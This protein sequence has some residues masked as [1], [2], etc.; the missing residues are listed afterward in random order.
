MRYLIAA[1]VLCA[2]AVVAA[3][4]WK[5]KQPAEW[6]EPEATKIL[7]ESPWVKS[8][9]PF[10]DPKVAR[11]SRSAGMGSRGGSGNMS[12]VGP[13]GTN[14]GGAGGTPLRLPPVRVSFETSAAVSDAKLRLKLQDLY[15]EQRAEN[16]VVSVLG[17]P[18]AGDVGRGQKMPDA[19]RRKEMQ[20]D[21]QER[22]TQMT[23]L[24][25][26]NDRVFQPA[27]VRLQKTV[28]GQVVLFVFRR[29][30]LNLH[31]DDKQIVFKT[32]MGPLEVD[33][34]FNLKE[35]VYQGKLSL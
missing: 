26:S 13:M 33:V 21:L 18:M 30:E 31:P 32:L 7:E 3:D 22:L 23:T 29:E 19:E 10:M 12:G 24:K 15:Q 20:E 34:K 25:L 2:G 16:V 5:S 27:E 9:T 1:T 14:A 4:F 8:T 17:M 28:N 11:S 35:M 6:T